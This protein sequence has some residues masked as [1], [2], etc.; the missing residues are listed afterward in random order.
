MTRTIFTALLLAGS[1]S[2]ARAQHA[3]IPTPHPLPQ[4]T[5][6]CRGCTDRPD[7]MKASTDMYDEKK[8]GTV[9]STVRPDAK[10]TKKTVKKPVAKKHRH[11]TV[12]K[13]TPAKAVVNHVV[14]KAKTDTLKK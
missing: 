13:K 3:P 5:T 7:P 14:A 12:K 1:V 8:A 9:S 11:K 2:V 10:P 4:S 6:D